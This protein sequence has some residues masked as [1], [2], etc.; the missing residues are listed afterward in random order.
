MGIK[1][2]FPFSQPPAITSYPE[3][4]HSHLHAQTTLP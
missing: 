2:S 3:P 4:Q 1:I